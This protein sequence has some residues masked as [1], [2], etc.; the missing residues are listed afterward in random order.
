MGRGFNRDIQVQNQG[1]QPLRFQGLKAP[2]QLNYLSDLKVRPT[3]LIPV[4]ASPGQ[5]S[6][7]RCA[8]HHTDGKVRE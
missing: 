2:L 6:A 8:S 1:L 3:I 4:R 5:R 7:A